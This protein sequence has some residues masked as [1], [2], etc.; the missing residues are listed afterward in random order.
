MR[1]RGA[2]R[3]R[4]RVGRR[5]PP[6]DLRRR[7]R[8]GRPD[9]IPDYKNFFDDLKYQPHN[10]VDGVHYGIPLG[11]GAEHAHVQHAKS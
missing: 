10:T 4:L 8:A 5:E 3:R 7:R 1:W 2:V 9:L 6:A 11:R